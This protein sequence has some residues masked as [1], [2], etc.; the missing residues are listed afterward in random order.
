MFGDN[1]RQKY[2]ASI[3][4]AHIAYGVSFDDLLFQGRCTW[5]NPV[6]QQEDEFEDESAS[7]IGD[8]TS[9]ISDTYAPANKRTL[10]LKGQIIYMPEWDALL[11]LGTPV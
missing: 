8:R 6:Q 3:C 5:Y 10:T 9:T 7:S 4:G 2:L 11:F 1:D